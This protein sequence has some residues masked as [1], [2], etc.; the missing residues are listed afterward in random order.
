M[1]P[2]RSSTSLRCPVELSPTTET[3][4]AFEIGNVSRK[5]GAMVHMVHLPALV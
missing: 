5:E 3:R 1:H 4:K 2:R